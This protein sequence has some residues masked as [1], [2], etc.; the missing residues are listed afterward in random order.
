VST[1]FEITSIYTGLGRR[2]CPSGASLVYEGVCSWGRLPGNWGTCKLFMSSTNWDNKGNY[3][4]YVGLIYG[5]EYEIYDTLFNG[6][7][8][9]DVPCAVCQVESSSVVMVPVKNTWFKIFVKEYQGYLM[10]GYPAHTT[11][12]EYVCVDGEA[13]PANKSLFHNKGGKLFYFVW[14]KCGAIKGPP[15]KEDDDLTRVV[16][17]YSHE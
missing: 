1:P 14:A 7:L 4:K 11:A 6:L 5:A 3:S 2:T 10:T 15:F 8:G 17:S 13:D 12:S 9:H 16:C